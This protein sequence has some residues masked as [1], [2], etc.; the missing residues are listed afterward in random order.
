MFEGTI[1]LLHAQRSM[2]TY[3]SRSLNEKAKDIQS[4]KDFVSEMGQSFK[5]DDSSIKKINHRSK[6]AAGHYVHGKSET[7]GT[8]CIFS[9][10]A[11]RLKERGFDNDWGGM[12]TYVN[13]IYCD[14]DA[15]SKDFYLMLNSIEIN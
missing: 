9:I 8:E 12:D 5:I 11:Y 6:Q 4:L 7:L 3:F 10:A 13:F 14:K 1:G 15:Y 2:S